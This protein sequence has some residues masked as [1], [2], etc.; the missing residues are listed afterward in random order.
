MPPLKIIFVTRARQRGPDKM[1]GPVS[2][3]DRALCA[4]D[5]CHVSCLRTLLTLNDFEFHTIAFG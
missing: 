2:G 4:S 1:P 5:F 3:A